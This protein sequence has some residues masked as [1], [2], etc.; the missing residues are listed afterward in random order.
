M[1]AVGKGVLDFPAI[2]AAADPN[3]LDWLIVEL[4]SCGTDMTEA[5]QDSYTYLIENGLAAGNK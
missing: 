5:V 3:V 1:T 2:I 4:D